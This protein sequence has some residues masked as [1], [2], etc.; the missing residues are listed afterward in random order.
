MKRAT[1]LC[2][3]ASQVHLVF[4]YLSP[5]KALVTCPFIVWV[6]VVEEDGVAP[7]QV[8]GELLVVSCYIMLIY[9]MSFA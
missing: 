4:F 7:H 9:E 2:A 1:F 5:A 8:D 3:E 6:A